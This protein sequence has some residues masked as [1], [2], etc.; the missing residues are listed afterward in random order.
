MFYDSKMDEGLV[1]SPQYSYIRARQLERTFPGD[2]WTGTWV[3]TVL[4]VGHGWG[5][6]PEE[7][8]PYDTSVWPP[9]EPP[10]LDVIAMKYRFNSYYRRARTVDACKSVLA[11]A[12]MPVVAALK[13]TPDWYNAPLGRISKLQIADNVIGI[14]SVLLV[15]YDD[16]RRDLR[17][18]NS[19]GIGWGDRG[20][21]YLPYDV[22]E[23]AC[24][25]SWAQLLAGDD[26]QTQRSSSTVHRSWGLLE[27]TGEIVHGHEI[28]GP[29]DER[30][31]WSYAVEQEGALQVE[32]LFVMPKFRR[33]GYGQTLAKSMAE[34]AE[35]K[36][37]DLQFLISH[38]DAAPENL[39]IIEKLMHPL[40]LQLN[41]CE[42]RWASYVYSTRE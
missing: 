5:A 26:A 30:I 19:W 23:E 32:E 10:G 22:F 40:G 21:G 20:F 36:V 2:R 27:S 15:G 39:R 28:K 24:V 6:L 3:V 31:A 35:Q 8:W 16:R 18:Q 25:E 14:H 33:R 17:F 42:Q 1:F 37:R 13:I 41:V 9:M 11:M 4:R 38:A 12:E 7:F 29:G 34:L